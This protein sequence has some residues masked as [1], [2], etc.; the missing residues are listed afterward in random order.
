SVERDKNQKIE[1]GELVID[2]VI[3]EVSVNKELAHLTRKEFE[4][5]LLLAQSPQ[6]VF[7]R[8]Q[9]IDRIWGESGYVT[10]RTVDVHVARLR[11]KLKEQG[12][13][14]KNRAGFGYRFDD[15]YS[16]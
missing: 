15:E 6:R 14:I 16:V 5:L 13:A 1:L 7:S 3:K 11:K 8:T 12:N 4:I 2:P 9:I 10:E